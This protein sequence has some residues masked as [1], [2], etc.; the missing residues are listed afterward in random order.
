MDVWDAYD[1]ACDVCGDAC[2]SCFGT[3]KWMAYFLAFCFL[4]RLQFG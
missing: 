1:D 2:D 3:L 4:P